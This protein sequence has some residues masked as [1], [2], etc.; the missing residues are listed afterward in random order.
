[1]RDMH[2][3]IV[4]AQLNGWKL[5]SGEFCYV[6]YKPGEVTETYQ[7]NMEGAL[8]WFDGIATGTSQELSK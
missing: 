4:H 2:G 6:A 5:V 3:N 7:G 8:V 1:M